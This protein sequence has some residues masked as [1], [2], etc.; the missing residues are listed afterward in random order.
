MG[1]GRGKRASHAKPKEQ[2]PRCPRCGYD[3]SGDCDRWKTECPLEGTCPECGLVFEW[4]YLLNPAL[5]APAWLFDTNRTKFWGPLVKTLVRSL[6]PPGIAKALRIEQDFRLK[7]SLMLFG[8][9]VLFVHV[10]AMVCGAVLELRDAH[11]HNKT[12]PNWSVNSFWGSMTSTRASDFAWGGA[13][14]TRLLWPY[15]D[16]F[17]ETSIQSADMPQWHIAWL[18]VVFVPISFWPLT[19]TLGIAK[20]RAAHLVRAACFITPIVGLFMWLHL[21]IGSWAFE[22][23]GRGM[24]PGLWRNVFRFYWYGSFSWLWLVAIGAMLSWWWWRS[25]RDYMKLPHAAGVTIAVLVMGLLAALVCT[26]F[27]D[28]E[29]IDAAATLVRR[30]GL[31]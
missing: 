3:V 28:H 6:W 22:V 29:L 2:H 17:D 25:V 11:Y 31:I 16:I 12:S 23:G 20:V 26:A 30:F 14:L 4:R 24:R 19:T 27:L 8:V 7:R 18:W 15:A 21:I 1:M 13:G 10:T 9:C 5:A